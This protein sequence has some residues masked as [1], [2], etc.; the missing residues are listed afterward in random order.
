MP[1]TEI[2]EGRTLHPLGMAFEEG[3][4]HSLLDIRKNPGGGW[5]RHPDHLGGPLELSGF[6]NLYQEVELRWFE[7][8]R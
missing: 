8:G 3:A 4:A 6:C 1:D 7:A 2:S 5:L